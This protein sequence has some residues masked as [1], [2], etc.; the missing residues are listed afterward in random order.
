MSIP[1]HR[2]LTLRT[3]ALARPRLFD[4]V[5]GASVFLM[6][7]WLIQAEQGG[8]R[9]PDALAYLFAFA[10]GALL[11]LRRSHPLT[12]L[13]LSVAGVVLYTLLGYPS[14]GLGLPLAAA[15]YS[16]AE[17]RRLRWPATIALSLLF[18]LFVATV[19]ASFV[20]QS[21]ENVL[22]LFIYTLAPE[23]A[24][25]AAVIA[26]GDGARSR[27]E[28]A[29]RSTRLL[30]ATA[31]QER[32]LAQA[33]A[34]TERAEIARELHDTLGHQTTVISMHAEVATEALA[35]D[36]Q[37]TQ[38]SLEIIS[39]TSRQMMQ[40]LR[41][42]VR[43]L[44]EH[45]VRPV[46]VSIAALEKTVFLDSTLTIHAD[47]AVDRPFGADV[48]AAAYRIVQEALTNISKHSA[49]DSARVA[50]REHGTTLEVIIDDQGPRRRHHEST[51]VSEGVGIV[52]MKERAEAL[53]GSV[54]AEPRGEGFRVHAHLLIPR[55][56]ASTTT[57]E[58]T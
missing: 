4:G 30:Q 57:K 31:D 24:L 27:R 52:G 20:R 7:G 8:I 12:V 14:I 40:D 23:V 5:L 46:R 49:A 15:L 13:V 48:E 42:T 37:M 1:L 50:I 6:L 43:T 2:D 58:L 47:I 36:R 17:Q 39:A 51:N 54:E 19:A 28:V 38:R 26:L 53:G 41:E 16:A 3:R 44:R 10:L 55:S 33:I 21:D 22:S 32:T 9:S 11:L 29:Q 35:R 25:M 18:L 45:E 34:A 56:A